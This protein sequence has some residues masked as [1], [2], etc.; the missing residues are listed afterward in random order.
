MG[1]RPTYERAK[2]VSSPELTKVSAQRRASTDSIPHFQRHSRKCQIC[3]H[4]ERKAIENDFFDWKRANWIA[5][6]YG[7][8]S[9]STIYRHARATGLDVR[10][11]A[12][13]R[14]RINEVPKKVAAIEK[15]S[16]SLILRAVRTLTSLNER[17]Q[18]VKPPAAH[19]V[20]S[21]TAPPAFSRSS[22]TTT[23]ARRAPRRS[24]MDMI[25][26]RR[27]STS[28]F[29]SQKSIASSLA[30]NHSPLATAV[31]NRHTHEKLELGVTHS[32]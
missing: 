15:P 16:V 9:R 24:P 11:H 31:P 10:R 6:R 20:V 2:L 22:S 17:R 23:A 27:G 8:H 28:A 29:K 25:S 26:G 30:T 19:R 32:N 18:R 12:N 5:Q 4:P 3:N 7:L 1:H 13:P 21:S 14:R